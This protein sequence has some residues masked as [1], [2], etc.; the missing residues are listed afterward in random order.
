MND[1]LEQFNDINT[2]QTFVQNEVEKH[3]VLAIL[4]YFIP[5]LFF[6]PA[7]AGD[8]NST[9]C[10]FHSNQG[11]TWLITLVVLSIVRVIFAFIPILGIL[12][13]LALSLLLVAVLVVLIIGAAKG[14]AYRIPFVGNLLNVF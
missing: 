13:N 9:Y 3:K 2:E 7:V 12:L 4:A 10:K 11:L 6:L 14:K 1:F 5:I 8:K